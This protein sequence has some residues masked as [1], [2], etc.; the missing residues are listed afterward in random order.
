VTHGNLLTLPVG[1][2]F[3]Y[4]QPVFVQSSGGTQVPRLQK[5]LVAFGDKIAFAD[6]LTEALDQL[7]GG[8][9]GAAGGDNNITPTPEPSP[10]TGTGTTPPTGDA[11]FQAALADAKAAMLARDAALKAGN[12]SEFAVQDQK[13]TD[14]VNRLIA[15][16][17]G[18]SATTK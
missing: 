2:G 4:V 5:I 13:L 1:G 18:G 17:S 3:L 12:L 6:T 15:L 16:E 11:A 7:F 8:D 9:S 10:G 14:A